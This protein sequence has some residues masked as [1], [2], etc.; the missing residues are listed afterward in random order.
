MI[1]YNFRYR[2]PFEYDK[3]V[4]NI[5][6]FSNEVKYLCEAIENGD[7]NLLNEKNNNMNKL[8]DQLTREDGFM[9][10]MLALGIRTEQRGITHGDK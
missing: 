4:L 8:F 6:Q 10:Q 1:K 9:Q 5:L 2:G 3:F 7:L